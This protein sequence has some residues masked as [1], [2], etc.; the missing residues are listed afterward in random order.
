MSKIF[1]VISEAIVKGD[2]V[3]LVG[4]GTFH[5]RN[6]K[7]RRILHPRTRESIELPERRV[8]QF[9]PGKKL[10]RM[11]AIQLDQSEGEKGDQHEHAPS[12]TQCEDS[13]QSHSDQ[14]TQPMND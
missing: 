5:A 6:R 11:T 1:D 10:K 7:R 3:L 13:N 8:V 14:N 12:Q 4:F 9:R 2:R